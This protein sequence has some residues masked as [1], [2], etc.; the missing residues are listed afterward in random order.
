[1]DQAVESLRERIKQL[2]VDADM[3]RSAINSPRSLPTRKASFVE[4][5]ECLAIGK[6]PEGS[7]WL[8]EIK[9]DGY[10][11]VAVKSAGAVMR[12]TRASLMSPP[13][14]GSTN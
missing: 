4:P 8:W 3:Q 6:L 12:P 10:R 5:M 9:L 13:M 14:I 7:Q 1:V 2:A 11:A